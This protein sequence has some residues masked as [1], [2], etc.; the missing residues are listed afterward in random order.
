MQAQQLGCANAIDVRR[1]Q[2]RKVAV[3]PGLTLQPA[4]ILSPIGTLAPFR[5]PLK[6]PL[7]VASYVC[8][9]P[10]PQEG[11]DAREVWTANVIFLYNR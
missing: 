8:F 9:Q 6:S 10:A 3:G 5:F 7:R 4:H 11:G 2:I 1:Q